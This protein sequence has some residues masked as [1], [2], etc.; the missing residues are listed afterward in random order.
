VEEVPVVSETI[1]PSS[2]SSSTMKELE[3]DI[4]NK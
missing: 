1:E 4:D 3:K 2:I